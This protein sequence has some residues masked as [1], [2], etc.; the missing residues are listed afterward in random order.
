M[1][2]S[3]KCWEKRKPDEN[4]KAGYTL[5]VSRVSACSCIISWTILWDCEQITIHFSQYYRFRS[6]LI[7]RETWRETCL[8]VLFDISWKYRSSGEN[9]ETRDEKNDWRNDLQ[10]V[11]YTL[12]ISLGLPTFFHVLFNLTIKC[13]AGLIGLWKYF[14]ISKRFWVN[15]E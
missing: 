6:F 9:G 14:A 8:I 11:I 7:L 3:V 2:I 15:Y 1:Q 5:I 4:S 13:I 12:L 10:N